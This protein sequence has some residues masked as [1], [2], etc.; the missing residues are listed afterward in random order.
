MSQQMKM[1]PRMI[2][3]MEILQL[4]MQELEQRLQEALETNIA[5]ELDDP[6]PDDR[7]VLEQRK[8]QD[9]IDSEGERELFTDVETNSEGNF[10]RL[11]TM[12]SAFSEDMNPDAKMP[13]TDYSKRSNSD[14]FSKMEAMKSEPARSAGL[15]EQLIN[16][17]AM[18]D[19]D[20]PL[21]KAGEHVINYID[22]DGYIR[23]DLETIIDQAPESIDRNLIPDAL[24]LLKHDLEPPGIGASTL[25]ECLLLQ[26]QARESENPDLDYSTERMILS[27]YA[28]DLEQ[29]RLPAIAK[30]SGLSIEEIQSA[31]NTLKELDPAPGRQ[32]IPT[33]PE[34]VI[35]DAIVEYDDSLNAYEV[36]LF[37]GRLPR[38]RIN[39]RYESMTKDQSVEKKT[40]DFVSENI[41]D[42]RWL[43]DAVDQRKNTL[44]RVVNAVVA[45]QQDFFDQ[46]P[47]ALKPL[48]MSQIADQL[49][50][51]VA[52][53]SRAVSGKWIQSPRGVIP[54]RKLF[55][56]GMETAD[57]NDI[58]GDSVKATLKDIIET[59][60]KRK[61][62]GD[63]QLTRALND[64]GIK[65]ARR[66]VAKYRQQLGYH[67]ARLRKQF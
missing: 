45:H 47:E 61:P 10:E 20:E 14:E 51:H 31:K 57:G 19:V 62:L 23:T 59:E 35:P 25:S 37:D 40:R 48:P 50:I 42:A 24:D 66:T 8:E 33:S 52:T 27:D 64:K 65:I 58:S 26:L 22:D 29:N 32:L 3:S 2:Q 6:A 1:T 13:S 12:E 16:Q 17:W 67:N 36:S 60:D 7:A 46:G 39:N 43:L 9:R 28:D 15:N 53:V 55:T 18:D 38:I 11:A 5:L 21:R 63:D 30:K 49:G 34:V 4:S 41:R 56:A 54:L 44:L